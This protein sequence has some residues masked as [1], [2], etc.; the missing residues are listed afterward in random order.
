MALNKA[1]EL[2]HSGLPG[3][4]YHSILPFICDDLRK[5]F[6]STSLCKVGAKSCNDEE[7]VP[8]AI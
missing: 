8:C 7:E 2:R 3:A 5:S 4:L 1:A 6:S